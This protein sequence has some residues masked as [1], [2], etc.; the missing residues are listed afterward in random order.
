MKFCCYSALS[1]MREKR[2]FSLSSLAK[3]LFIYLTMSQSSS[4]LL[5]RQ[6]I[7]SLSDIL[8]WCLCYMWN[9]EFNM[10][11]DFEIDQM[12]SIMYICKSCWCCTSGKYVSDSERSNVQY[13]NQQHSTASEWW[14][15]HKAMRHHSVIIYNHY[16][17]S[18]SDIIMIK[19]DVFS[20]STVVDMNSRLM[21]WI[22]TNI[23][24]Q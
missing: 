9:C 4:L 11:T 3:P 18:L 7:I 1:F 2:I 16:A 20:C 24:T 6:S 13:D 19:L 14:E 10:V 12:R 23:L 15:Y 22:W 21:M 17:S 8:S 5:Q